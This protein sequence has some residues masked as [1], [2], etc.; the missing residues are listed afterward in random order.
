MTSDIGGRSGRRPY[1]VRWPLAVL[2]ATLLAVLA[3]CGSDRDSPGVASLNGASTAP[4]A[5]AA[6]G[7]QEQQAL[8]LA[9][10]L[11]E[12]GAPDFPDPTVDA[13]GSVHFEFP[14]SVDR[15]KLRPAF[16]ACRQYAEGLNLGRGGVD[17]T[18]LQDALVKYAQCMRANGYQMADP[19]LSGGTGTPPQGGPF[20]EID[21]DDPAYRAAHPKCEQHLAQLPSAAGGSR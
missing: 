10:C 9:A 19:D 21:R 13:D 2:A 8:K 12:N 20:A 11:R 15:T 17:R 3:G 5:S 1:G 14:A 4:S 7:D 18:Q 6:A 16:Q